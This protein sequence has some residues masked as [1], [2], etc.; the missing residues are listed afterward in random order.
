[1]NASFK[2]YRTLRFADYM[3]PNV[4]NT[5]LGDMNIRRDIQELIYKSIIPQI[6]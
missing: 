3:C 2:K 1:M 5:K 4:W 6:P